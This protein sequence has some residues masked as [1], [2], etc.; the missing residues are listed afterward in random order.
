MGANIRLAQLASQPPRRSYSCRAVLGREGVSGRR[1]PAETRCGHN[2]RQLRAM[3]TL[4]KAY[5][6]GLLWDPTGRARR[7]MKPCS[8]EGNTCLTPLVTTSDREDHKLALLGRSF[9]VCS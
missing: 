4:L 3:G 1:H 2:L 5:T 6:G 7:L 9:S 8:S